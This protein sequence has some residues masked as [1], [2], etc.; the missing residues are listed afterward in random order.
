MEYEQALKYTIGEQFKEYMKEFSRGK[1]S[2]KTIDTDYKDG[3][4]GDHAGQ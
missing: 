4:E 3:M 1:Y 2:V